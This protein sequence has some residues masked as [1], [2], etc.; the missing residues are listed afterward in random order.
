MNKT[1]IWLVLD[2]N[3]L[4]W[5]AFHKLKSLPPDEIGEHVT[6]FFFSDILRLQEQFGSEKTA[7]CFDGAGKSLRAALFSGYKIKR[8]QKEYTDDERLRFRR[9]QDAVEN[10]RDVELKAHGFQNIFSEPGYEADDMI[11]RFV[12][13]LWQ[14][15][16]SII[17]SSDKDLYQLINGDFIVFYDPIKN[18]LINNDKFV[19]QYGIEP[20]DWWK[21]KALSGCPSDSVNGING[22]GEIKAIQYLKGELKSK[23]LQ[24]KIKSEAGQLIYLRNREIVRLPFDNAGISLINIGDKDAWD[25][26]QKKYKINHRR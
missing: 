6:K 4:L 26:V 1:S 9:F 5:R 18:K 2:C 13:D 14:L 25:S 20:P 10:L 11:A 15:G 7:F 21:V 24:D 23:L 19:N 12:H 16:I 8:K 3:F 22:I 17:V